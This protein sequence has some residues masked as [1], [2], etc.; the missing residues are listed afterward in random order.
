MKHILRSALVAA[1]VVGLLVGAS[2]VGAGATAA[3]VTQASGRLSHVGT[4]DGV[5]FR[6]EVPEDWNGT[7]VLYSHGYQPV[8]FPVF[9]GIGLTNRPPD[10]ARTETWL[11][12]HGYAMAASLFQN[13]GRGFQVETAQH[14]QLAVLDWFEANVGTPVHT[15]A[16]GQSL[17]SAIAVQLVERNPDRFD[18]LLTMCSAYDPNAT[19][20]AALDMQFAIRTLLAPGQD[21]P[22]VHLT[23]PA[24]S[25]QALTDA[26]ARALE[27]P[28]GQARLALVGALNNVAGWYSTFGPRPTDPTDRIRQQA[29]WIANAYVTG[30][31]P[32]ARADLEQ[33]LGGN[34]SSNVGIDYGRQLAL[35]SQRQEV[36]AAYRAAGL[37]LRNDLAALAAAPRIAAD[38]AAAAHM[39]QFVPQ[40]TAGVPTVTIHT[41]GDGGAVPDQE[42][43]YGS[44]VRRAGDR[45]L[46]RQLYVDR[47]MHCAFTDADEIVSL[48]TL[49]ERIDTGHWPRTTPSHLNQAVAAFPPD[50]Q[51]VFDFVE[52][53]QDG[54]MPPGFVHFTPPSLLRPSR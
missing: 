32:F 46:I 42:R 24:A 35:S 39:Q 30:L 40:G 52:T 53:F 29:A 28:Q 54:P 36:R 4:I 3:P 27:T 50:H 20:N 16:T 22:L 6:V 15:V 37:D 49:F 11:L 9:P 18:G 43:W 12:D 21:I 33:H 25:A 44:Q 13:D 23:D 10:R 51:L 17:G 34:P 38:P 14:D 41:V 8:Q 2:A 19:F 47:G 1:T 5:P 45:G 26:V 31:G 7:L 48:Q